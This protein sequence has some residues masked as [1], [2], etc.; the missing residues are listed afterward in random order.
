MA[1]HLTGAASA[2]LVVAASVA[3]SVATTSFTARP[4]PLASTTTTVIRPTPNVLRSVQELARLESVSFHMERVID[5]HDEQERAFGL[6]HAEDSILLVAVGE[7]TAGVDLA[8]L[9]PE[10]VRVD[11]A[12]GHVTLTLPAPQVFSSRL[13]NERTHVHR[14]S[15]ELLARRDESLESRARA[16]A[17]R[18]I[19]QGA[20]ES[21][22]LDRAK[23]SAAQTVG[24]LVRGLGF[25]AVDI[26][27]R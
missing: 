23:A 24:G 15:T 2:L 21:H 19:R 4:A 6:V 17:E 9:R 8:A 12:T 13:D 16:E 10:D 26:R 25:S 27:W 22:L 3:A 1:K 11:R 20:L 5:L 14:R 18:S 7:V